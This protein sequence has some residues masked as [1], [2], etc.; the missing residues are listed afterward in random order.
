[1]FSRF[2]AAWRG[3]IAKV[4]SLTLGPWDD[5]AEK[6]PLAVATKDLEGF[7]PYSIAVTRGHRQLARIIVD[8][9]RLQYRPKESKRQQYDIA[10]SVSDCT[11]DDDEANELNLYGTLVDDVYT[12]ED[13]GAAA[14]V[15]RCPTSPLTMVTSQ[16]QL[17]RLS[18]N[19]LASGSF[20]AAYHTPDSWVSSKRLLYLCRTY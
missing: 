1:M 6:L 18:K 10:S 11:D 17:W 19:A 8:I 13:L 16:F 7:N 9:A 2:E 15:V 12:V 4:K 5:V 20:G 3:D 14:D